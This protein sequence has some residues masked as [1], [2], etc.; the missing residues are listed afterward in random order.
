MEKKLSEKL[1]ELRESKKLSKEDLAKI[2]KI[3]LTQIEILEKGDF[4]KIP[5][6]LL[7]KILEK[8]EGFFNLNKGEIS[9]LEDF[10]SED[11]S[12]KP[13]SL[14]NFPYII[15]IIIG[16]LFF[17]YEISGLVL[18]PKIKIFYPKDNSYLF[19]KET[20]IKG[21]VD[22]R[23]IFFINNEEIVPD[24]NGYF[25]KKVILKNGVN[26]FFLEAKNYWGVYNRKELKLYY[27]GL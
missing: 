8:Y 7:K 4:Y 24:K 13:K 18:P 21:Y 3:T 15:I 26:R 14:R 16:A 19:T 5:K 17:I 9:Y 22:P 1:K 12:I 27:M 6:P 2:L 20:Y 25:E 23:T 11:I 10:K